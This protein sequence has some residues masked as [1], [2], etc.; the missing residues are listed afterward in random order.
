MLCK[1]FSQHVALTCKQYDDV[2]DVIECH[3]IYF[4]ILFS[5]TYRKYKVCSITY[6][7]TFGHQIIITTID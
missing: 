7:D 5:I 1:P 6:F 2:L 4:K 3:R